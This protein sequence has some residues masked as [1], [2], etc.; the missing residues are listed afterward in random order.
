MKKLTLTA[1]LILIYILPATLC[2]AF[3]QQANF[4]ISVTIPAIPG[5]NVALE[6]QSSLETPLPIQ[7]KAE[8]V[9]QDQQKTEPHKPS[10]LEI[11]EKKIIEQEEI[12]YVTLIER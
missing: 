12:V 4:Q 6:T 3:G 2:F 10:I 1:I 5:V 8:D 9:S 7:N 11:I